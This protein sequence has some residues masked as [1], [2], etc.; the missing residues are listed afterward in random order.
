MDSSLQKNEKTLIQ[1]R[2]PMPVLTDLRHRLAPRY[3]GNMTSLYETL[4]RTFLRETPWEKG[5]RWRDPQENATKA[6]PSA[7]TDPLWTDFV[8]PFPNDLAGRL[9]SVAEKNK[10]NLST[11]LYTATYYFIWY[12][13]PT[14]AIK[15]VREDRKRQYEERER[16]RGDEQ[17]DDAIPMG[18]PIRPKPSP[19][20]LSAGQSLS[21]PD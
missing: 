1:I 2:A 12:K 9:Q 16:R 15:A 19:S 21:L 3:G 6:S 7:S 11:V 17:D 18:A 10:V 8:V 14:A 13:N 4:T 5:L 20:P